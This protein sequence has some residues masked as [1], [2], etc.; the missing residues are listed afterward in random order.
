MWRVQ[1][2]EFALE[3]AKASERI[4]RVTAEHEMLLLQRMQLLGLA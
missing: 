1:G 2:K 3:R 4:M